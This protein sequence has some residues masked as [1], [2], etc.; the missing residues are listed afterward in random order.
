MQNLELFV[1]REENM[2]QK[3]TEIMAHKH[4]DSLVVRI[5][6]KHMWKRIRM[7]SLHQMNL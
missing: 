5:C 2:G 1:G 6:H 7:Y 3:M 4:H